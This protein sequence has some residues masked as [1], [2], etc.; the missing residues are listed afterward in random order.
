[1][2]VVPYLNDLKNID[3][4]SENLDDYQPKLEI[5]IPVHNE[6]KNI[7]DLLKEIDLRLTEHHIEYHIIFVDDGSV[8]DTLKMLRM[9]H[10]TNRHVNYISF[11]KQFGKES[12]MLAGLKEAVEHVNSKD[13]VAIMDA[14]FQ[15]PPEELPQLY[16]LL[17]NNKD[18]DSIAAKRVNYKNES[19]FG[20]I[21]SKIFY[22]LDNKLS[23]I[24]MPVGARDFRIMRMPKLK[25]V[26]ELSERDRFSR[27]LFA[28]VGMKTYYV[29][30]TDEKRRQGKS[31]WNFQS[32]FR[33]ATHGLVGNPSKL[34]Q[35]VTEIGGI[36]FGIGL[37]G[38]II[39]WLNS[40]NPAFSIP[41]A[42]HILG[43]LGILLTG[44]ILGC[45]GLAMIYLAEIMQE[46]KKRPLYYI[47]E[48]SFERTSNE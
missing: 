21:S 33:Y 14:D 3:T 35:I 7:K 25:Q 8:D 44:V 37:L 24:K 27:Y 11:A 1:M 38:M 47:K 42:V 41:Y 22:W 9:L 48:T 26:V 29:N 17:Q 39:T 12:A 34:P 19:K 6:N 13:Y 4:D 43:F 16:T 10:K 2:G 15:D 5:V 18:Y 28:Y 32:L 45:I 20:R 40:A 23:D 31:S 36:M 30:I 46:V